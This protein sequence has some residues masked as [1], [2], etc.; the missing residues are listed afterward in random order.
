MQIKI[1]GLFRQEDIEY[2]NEALPEYAGFVFYEKSRRAV[3]PEQA[4]VYRKRL[5]GRIQA[6]GVFVDE[7]PEKII[8]LLQNGTI[9][10]AQLHGQETEETIR[11]IQKES[12]KPVWKSVIVKTADDVEKWQ[13]SRADLLLFDGGMGSAHTFPWEYLSGLKRP[14]F[15]AGGMD[16]EKIKD[17]AK[18]PGVCGIDLSS[19][20]ETEGYKDRQKILDVVKCVRK[21]EQKSEERT[22]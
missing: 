14:F 12:G 7:E 2:I 18:L 22:N 3:T 17:A 10:I 16:A 8:A 20:V 6:V 21:F 13:D 5:D 11:K 1:C 4:G 15:L 19:S 9:D